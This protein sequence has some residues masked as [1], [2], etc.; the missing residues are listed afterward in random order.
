MVAGV[1]HDGTE[2]I[3][4]IQEKEPDI[5]ILDMI[6]PKVDGLG[7]LEKLHSMRE[8]Q[9]PKVIVI[10]AIGQDTLVQ[11]ALS[12]GAE[13]YMV[14]PFDMN[15]FINRIRQLNS[16]NEFYEKSKEASTVSE[17]RKIETNIRTFESP[18]LE[19]QI[20]ELIHQIGIP[21]HMRGYK[22]I[23]EAINIYIKEK[24]Q[25]T[26]TGELYPKVAG[27]FNSTPSRV[28]R[29]IRHAIEVAC[30]RGQTDLIKRILGNSTQSSK[31][32]PSNALV[33]AELSDFIRLNNKEHGLA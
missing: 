28:E 33:I 31:G 5:L 13:Y 18:D 10:S 21:V 27:K 11:R 12:L 24:G 8:K 2:A 6:M 3:K 22:Y 26:I 7:I 1:A 15:T 9:P 14:K 32:K 16:P 25:L 4:L 29:S 23:K 30:H 20:T 19:L 17:T